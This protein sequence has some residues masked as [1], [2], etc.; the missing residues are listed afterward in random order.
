LVV[1]RSEDIR[2]EEL[3]HFSDGSINLHGRRLVFHDVHALAQLRKDLVDTIGMDQTRRI[4]SRFGYYWG[5]DD[6]SV[7]NRV[8]QWEDVSEWL[9]AGPRLQELQGVARVEVKS[10]DLGADGRCR[11]EVVWHDSVEAEEHLIELGVSPEAGCWIL[12][13][14]ASGYASFCLGR[15]VYF[16]ETTCRARGDNACRAIGMD[17]ESWG[18]E[19]DALVKNY[20]VDDIKGKIEELTIALRKRTLELVRQQK[21]LRQTDSPAPGAPALPEIRSKSFRQVLDV[22]K[23]VARFDSSVLITGESGVGKEIVARFVHENSTRNRAPFVAV[24][25]GA[26]PESLLESELFG[27]KSGSF[28]GAVRDRE[29]LFEQAERGTIFLDEIGD[30]SPALQTK[31]LRV[32]QEKQI[33][34]VGENRVRDVDTRIIAATN[35][36]LD[37]EVR[38]GRFREDL[39]YRLRVVEIHI[40]PL[41]ERTEDILPLARYFT[42]RLARRMKLER[43]SLDAACLPVLERYAWPGNV[44]ELEN[45]I[46]RAAVMC[47]DGRIRAEHLPPS[48][49]EPEKLTAR[50]SSATSRTLV[51]VERDYVIAVLKACGGNRTRAAKTLGIGATTLWRKLKDWGEK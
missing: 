18:D 37:R 51:E 29:G 45:A 2:L 4:F 44:R 14:Y 23:R 11:M 50:E 42:E 19:A 35:R 22:G 43:L 5:E 27:H 15:Q 6:A 9:R 20:K 36:E 3:I 21:R 8:Y 32:I 40:P 31:L 12:Q 34:R 28:T 16:A 7:V 26:L 33:R 46:E 1:V 30:V 39:F 48:I 47:D 38:E 41:R 13:G 49:A 17:K 25:C 10:L 24:D